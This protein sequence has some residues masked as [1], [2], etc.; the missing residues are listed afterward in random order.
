M[1]RPLEIAMFSDYFHPELGGIQDS[2]ALAAQAL[3][4]RGHRV[5]LHVPRYG[6]RDYRRVGLRRVESAL[7]PGV[8]VHRHRSLPAPSTTQQSRVVIPSMVTTLRLLRQTRPDVIHVQSFLGLGLEAVMAGWM[9]GIPVIGTNHTAIKAFAAYLPVKPDWAEDYVTWFHNR[10]DLITA[11]SHSVLEEMGLARLERPSQIISNPI[12]THVFCPS[13]PEE[14]AGL[15]AQFGLTTSVV[16]YAGR[17][18]PEKDIDVVVRAVA[19]LRE[20]GMP[21]TL[22][23]AG[24]G[25]DEGRLRGMAAELGVADNVRF[26]GTLDKER[27]AALLRASDV[28]AIM[29]T[30]ETQS[31]TLLQAMACGVPVVAAR[32]RALPEFVNASN[33]F[34]VEP[35]DVTGLADR[36]RHLLE[37]ECTRM[38]I[39]AGGPVSI[40]PYGIDHVTDAWEQVYH[41]LSRKEDQP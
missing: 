30:S 37:N 13:S 19:R 36:L 25:S 40:R 21:M 41:G 22:A 2:I 6:E 4:R 31:M 26:L 32:A 28:F 15:R 20:G 35:G 34:L 27:L 7:G 8:W 9:L 16:V 11:P 29:S 38:E 18:G 3:G 10:C 17:L 23:I 24:H 14:R 33:G 39:G 5:A 1:T 12:D